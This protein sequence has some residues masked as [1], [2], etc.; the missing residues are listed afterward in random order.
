MPSA[1][2]LFLSILLFSRDKPAS[3]LAGKLLVWPSSSRKV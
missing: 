3:R 2:I 1:M